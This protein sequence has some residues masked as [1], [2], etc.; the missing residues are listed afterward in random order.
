M[1]IAFDDGVDVTKLL[2][3]DYDHTILR[4]PEKEGKQVVTIGYCYCRL[5][6]FILWEE[7]PIQRSLLYGFWNRR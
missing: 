3:C 5:S 6:L 1:E 4:T 2:G 7:S